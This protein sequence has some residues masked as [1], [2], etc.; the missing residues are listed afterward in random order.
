MS[1]TLSL[2]L[3]RPGDSCGSLRWRRQ[4]RRRRILLQHL[5]ELRIHRG[6][7]AADSNLRQL[8]AA[9]EFVFERMLVGQIRRDLARFTRG[10]LDHRITYPQPSLRRQLA[11][12]A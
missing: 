4:R 10:D 9:R 8:V 1:A 6:S 12:A 2:A 7:P 11:W 3:R 5:L